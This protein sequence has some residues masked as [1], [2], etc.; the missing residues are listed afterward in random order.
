[1]SNEKITI[2]H[3]MAYGPAFTFGDS[4]HSHP[5]L[6]AETGEVQKLISPRV[7]YWVKC[8]ILSG[9]RESKGGD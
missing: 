4:S 9:P 3:T 2:Y 1:M 7:F 5:Q 6:E 8:P